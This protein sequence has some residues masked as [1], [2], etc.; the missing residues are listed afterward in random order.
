MLQALL[1]KYKPARRLGIADVRRYDLPLHNDSGSGFLRLL[2]GLMALLTVMALAACFALNALE[3]R[4][5]SGLKGQFTVEVPAAHKNRA[6]EIVALLKSHPAVENAAAMS[7][8]DLHSML[9]PWLGEKWQSNDIPVPAIISVS[10]KEGGDPDL[11]VLQKRLDTVISGT[12]LDAHES[13]MDDVLRFTGALTF[14]AALLTIV[15]ISTVVIAVIGGVRTRMEIHREELQLLHLMG[16]TDT[17]IARQLMRH[18][19]FLALQGALM[20]AV[21]A[22]LMILLTGWIAG[23]LS[24]TL[25]PGFHLSAGHWLALLTCPLLLA[26]MAMF[27]ARITALHEL[28]R[29]P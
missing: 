1:Q 26:L 15:I 4:W 7:D 10:L 2:L 21:I 22:A 12:R 19:F 24:V 27:V 13:W 14:S 16:A 25:L 23:Q 28:V 11:A 17:Y 9:A 6:D 5:V 8:D 29:M 20:G 3:Q 18:S